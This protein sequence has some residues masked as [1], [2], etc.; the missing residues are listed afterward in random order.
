MV[1]EDRSMPKMVGSNSIRGEERKGF[2]KSFIALHN[3]VLTQQK[4]ARKIINIGKPPYRI[5]RPLQFNDEEG[6]KWGWS[7]ME[8]G[9]FIKSFFWLVLPTDDPEQKLLPTQCPKNASTIPVNRASSKENSSL[10][11][12]WP[13]LK[14]EGQALLREKERLDTIHIFLFLFENCILGHHRSTWI[15]M[16][17]FTLQN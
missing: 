16:Q 6:M 15:K 14:I 9:I 13:F 12:S 2:S 17:V 4:H 3:Q 5:S 7:K 8:K 11:I 1:C 10:C